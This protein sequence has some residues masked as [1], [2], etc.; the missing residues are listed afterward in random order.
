MFGVTFKF[1]G[2]VKYKKTSDQGGIATF[3][4]CYE[5]NRPFYGIL[6]EIEVIRINVLERT[7]SDGRIYRE[8]AALEKGQ[9]TDR[10]PYYLLS[11]AQRIFD[12]MS[13]E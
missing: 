3:H 6:K 4:F 9:R 5:N 8:A 10:D 2:L 7:L 1:A 11:R 13:Q 12:D